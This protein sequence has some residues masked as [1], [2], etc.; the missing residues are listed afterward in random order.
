MHVSHTADRKAMLRVLL[1][2]DAHLLLDDLCEETGASKGAVVA[3]GL[4]CLDA[5]EAKHGKVVARRDDAAGRV[6][7]LLAGTAGR[8]WAAGAPALADAAGCSVSAVRAALKKLAR[9]GLVWRADH[10]PGHPREYRLTES[11]AAAA[12]AA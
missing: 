9:D 8:S 3:A 12:G 4:D 10:V 1:R 5:S 11:G 7:R 2:T 6:L